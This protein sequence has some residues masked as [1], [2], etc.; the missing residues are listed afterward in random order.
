MGF[1]M[2][3]PGILK[4]VIKTVDIHTHI[5]PMV[6]DGPDELGEAMEMLEIAVRNGTSH[7]VLTPHY[8]TDDDRSKDLSKS[9]LEEKFEEFK[10]VAL[11]EGCEISLYFGAEVH[12]T[13]E[14]DSIIEKN[15]IITI[16]NTKYVLLEFDFSEESDRALEIT[17]K[18]LNAGYLP[19]IAHPER[20]KFVKNDPALI[21]P[22]VQEGAILQINSSSI[23]GENGAAS[24][25][26]ALTIINSELAS[27]VAS[28]SHGVFYRSPDLSEAYAFVSSIFSRRSSELLFFENPRLVLEG[29][30]TKTV[31]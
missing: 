2:L 28:D 20:Y 18:I 15:E 24:Q 21:I 3:K 8:L 12:V 22:F 9:Q 27:I 14:I 23:L 16:N 11:E 13:K 17:K 5:L 4:A 29:K 6:D 10:K 7:I 26:A 19:I 31:R 1:C 30:P 25:E